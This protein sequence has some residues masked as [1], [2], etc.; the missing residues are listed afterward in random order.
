M[1]IF[2][3]IEWSLYFPFKNRTQFVRISNGNRFSIRKPDKF[4]RYCNG[5]SLSIRKPDHSVF[6]HIYHLMNR[7]LSGIRMLTVLLYSSGLLCRLFLL[8]I[9]CGCTQHKNVVNGNIY[10]PWN[11]KLINFNT[12]FFICRYVYY[13]LQEF[14]SL[15]RRFF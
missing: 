1:V 6:G 14:L 8:E 13:F 2:P 3:V 15:Q 11:K 12:N 5:K 9:K 4:V 7:T 10:N